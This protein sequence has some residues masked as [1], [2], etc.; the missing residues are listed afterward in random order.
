MNPRFFSERHNAPMDENKSFGNCPNCGALL[1][2]ITADGSGSRFCSTRC[3]REW[4]CPDDCPYCNDP[5]FGH[6]KP[7]RS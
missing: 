5:H 7:H 6:P 1:Q 2:A 4:E 3:L